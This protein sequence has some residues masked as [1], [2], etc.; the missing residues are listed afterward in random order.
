[1][2]VEVTVHG[3]GRDSEIT[4]KTLFKNALPLEV[5]KKIQQWGIRHYDWRQTNIQDGDTLDI[6]IGRY[7]MDRW[8]KSITPV[9]ELKRLL[10]V[11][12]DTSE[13]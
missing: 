10:G 7:S 11:T 8:D 6:N 12:Q 4:V 1:M 5:A 13:T 2:S 3:E 9:D